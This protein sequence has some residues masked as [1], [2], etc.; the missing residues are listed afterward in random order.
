MNARG[1]AVGRLTLAAAAGVLG[2][3][4][5]ESPREYV[6]I[7]LVFALGYLFGMAPTISKW[8]EEKNNEGGDAHAERHG[9]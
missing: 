9:D 8:I 1:E 2:G 5:V 7:M 3:Q 6:L 4:L